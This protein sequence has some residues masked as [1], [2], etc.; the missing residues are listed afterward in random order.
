MEKGAEE[1]V[2][3]YAGNGRFGGKCREGFFGEMLA[4]LLGGI[5]AIIL[6]VSGTKNFFF[7]FGNKVKKKW[8]NRIT[9][10][11]IPYLITSNTIYII[12]SIL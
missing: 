2:E 8:K 12:N 1:R 3:F 5:S 6:L 4:K 11:I 10:L 9:F 7:V